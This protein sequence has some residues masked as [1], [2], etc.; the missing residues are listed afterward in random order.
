ML[1]NQNGKKAKFKKNNI[2]KYVRSNKDMTIKQNLI[3]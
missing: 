1:A 3:V 2:Y